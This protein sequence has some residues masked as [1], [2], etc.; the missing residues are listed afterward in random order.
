MLAGVAGYAQDASD[1]ESLAQLKRESRI[2]ES[3]VREV[4]QQQFNHPYAIA[5]EPKAAYLEGYGVS[6]TFHLRINRGT[7]R[8]FYR[9]VESPLVNAPGTKSK[10]LQIVR[11][12]MIDTLGNFGGTL[13]KIDPEER[14]AICAHVE[15]RNEL[16]QSK[17]RLIIVLSAKK[18]DIDQYVTR[19]ITMAD[20]KKRVDVVEY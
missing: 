10:Q 3:I 4:L 17:N 5:G 20:F 2:F 1:G 15:D 12:T 13:K 14:I 9:E 18:S 11:S 6:L 16:D 7:I 8:T 19:A